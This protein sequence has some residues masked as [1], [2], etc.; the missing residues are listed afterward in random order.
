MAKASTANYVDRLLIK[1]DGALC[2]I[3]NSLF[4]LVQDIPSPDVL[5][6]VMNDLIQ[7]A[8]RLKS[9]WSTQN[10]G[11]EAIE[12]DS[13]TIRA[14]FQF[15]EH[16][17]DKNARLHQ[18]IK[19]PITLE[20]N[21]PFKL[22][23]GKVL[24]KQKANWVIGFQI[25][26]AAGD[27]MA[28]IHLVQRYWD[29]LNQVL[30]QNPASCLPLSAPQMTDRTILSKLWPYKKVLPYVLQGKYR[31]LSRRGDALNHRATS[32]GN[33]VL[34]SFRVPLPASNYNSSEFFYS[35]LLAAIVA[36][37]QGAA[38]KIIRL[39]LPVDLRH[40][41]AIPPNSIENGCAAVVLEFSLNTLRDCYFNQP[42]RLGALVKEALSNSLKKRVYLSNAL[43][44][45]VI[46]HIAKA[47]SLKNT[48]RNELLAAKRSSTLVI[49]HFGDLTQYLKPPLSIKV[50]GIQSH[51]PVWGSNSFVYEG[52]LYTSITCFDGIWSEEQMNQ[53]ST[54]AKDWLQTVY[55]LQGEML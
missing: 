23:V 55:N 30:Y 27:G 5:I 44:C 34:K 8:P 51:T 26:H 9:V 35:A 10:S 53:F 19:T 25:H 29:L 13:N 36:W 42:E 6:T 33:P 45:I 46:S 52:V 43:E 15:D 47:T 39:R 14:A 1:L 18:L 7:E 17:L 37:E 31:Q 12:P 28:L 11:W 21:L 24:C 50:L 32:I 20:K 38:D 40:F 22:S 2:P 41:L 3:W 54:F 4:F 49:T 16:A 48:A